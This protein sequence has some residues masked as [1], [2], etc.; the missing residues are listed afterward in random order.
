K[1]FFLSLNI[2]Y[3]LFSF[4]VFCSS[5]WQAFGISVFIVCR[6]HCSEIA[7]SN[8]CSRDAAFSLAEWAARSRS[9]TWMRVESKQLRALTL[10]M[11]TKLKMCFSSQ[12]S[13]K[14]L[15]NFCN[16]VFAWAWCA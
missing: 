5:V 14:P 10:I 2:C 12:G 6:F 4:L 11:H 7:S 8:F 13:D 15:L 1:S 9:L 3:S 16:S